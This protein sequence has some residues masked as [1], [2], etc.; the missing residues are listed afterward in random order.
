[1]LSIIDL[2]WAIWVKQGHVKAHMWSRGHSL[3]RSGLNYI[4]WCTGVIKWKSQLTAPLI[5]KLQVYTNIEHWRTPE[6]LLAYL[7]YE[8]QIEC[9]LGS[10]QAEESMFTMWIISFFRNH[11]LYLKYV[12][13]NFCTY[14]TLQIFASNLKCLTF[15]LLK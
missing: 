12:P 5:I 13:G 3:P 11:G 7:W 1:M 9:T 10:S 2:T 15:H 8:L 6:E 14:P 4:L